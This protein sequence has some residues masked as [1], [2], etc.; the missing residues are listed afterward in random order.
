MFALCGNRT[1]DLLR[2]SRVFHHY[3]K[4][5][6]RWKTFCTTYWPLWQVLERDRCLQG[7]AYFIHTIVTYIFRRILPISYMPSPRKNG[8]AHQ[9]FECTHIA[10][11]PE[12]FV[13]WFEPY[14]AVLRA[15]ASKGILKFVDP[16]GIWYRK[17][18]S[19]SG[20]SYVAL[21]G[22]LYTSLR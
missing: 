9:T 15:T 13:T 5:A 21:L 3:A 18:S 17:V 16:I 19:R 20:S 14:H 10:F 7:V 1:G 6:V 2:S 12:R 22:L 4:A 11:V 8:S